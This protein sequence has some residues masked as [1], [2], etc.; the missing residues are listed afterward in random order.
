V[1]DAVVPTHGKGKHD[2]AFLELFFELPNKG[3]LVPSRV[4]LL[5]LLLLLYWPPRPRGELC[6]RVH[7]RAGFAL[8]EAAY[9]RGSAGGGS[10]KHYEQFALVH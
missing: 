1:R 10:R 2:G 3:R 7:L 4:L 9:P 8:R 6:E 5:L